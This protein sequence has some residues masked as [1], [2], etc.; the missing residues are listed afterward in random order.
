[1]GV[2]KCRPGDSRTEEQKDR[3]VGLLKLIVAFRHFAST[4]IVTTEGGAGDPDS[5]PGQ[6]VLETL[7]KK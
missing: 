7:R 3:Q 6:S 1:M 5:I 2:E 4:K